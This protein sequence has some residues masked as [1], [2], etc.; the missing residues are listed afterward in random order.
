MLDSNLLLLDPAC[1]SDLTIAPHSNGLS[2]V[3][4]NNRYVIF[5]RSCPCLFGILTAL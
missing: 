4:A 1:L 3:V 5:C 2:V